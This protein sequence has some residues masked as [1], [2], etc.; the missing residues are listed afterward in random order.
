MLFAFLSNLLEPISYLIFSIAFIFQLR[1]D[2]SGKVKVLLLNYVLSTL[3]M[4]Y[5]TAKA[6]S[7]QDNRWVYNILCFQTSV[8]ICYYFHQLFTARKFR[9]VVKCLILLNVLYFLVNDIILQHLILFDSFGYS[10]LSV[11]ISVMAFMYFYQVFTHVSEK[12]I[13]YDFNFWLVSAYLIYFLVSF[14]IFLTY[15]NLTDRILP[16]YT[17]EERR[18]LT[19]LWIV[20]NVLLFLSAI[21]TLA[22]SLWTTY[23]N[24]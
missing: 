13:W 24:R 2:H 14:G 22:G 19:M 6:F 21:I 20:Q 12:K 5:A 17:D 3:L 9:I 23:R 18:L 10:L 15:H 8:C 11:S 7:Q 1:K 4:V 16:T